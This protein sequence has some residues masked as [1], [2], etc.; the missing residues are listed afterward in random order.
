MFADHALKSWLTDYKTNGISL[1]VPELVR[2]RHH[3]KALD[4][5]PKKTPQA[6]LAGTYVT[7]LKGRG[8]EF[9]ESRHY[10]AGDDIRAIDWRVTARTGKT[11]TKVYREERERPIYVFTDMSSSMQFGSAFVFKSI[12]AAHLSTLIAW[13]AVA[14]GDK[15]GAISFNAH[16]HV[17]NKP[18][19]RQSAVLQHIH[20]LIGLQ[21]E[22][23]NKQHSDF[24]FDPD[25]QADQFSANCT[26]LMRLAKP[27]S[28]V[29]VISDFQNINKQSLRMLADLNRHSEVRAAV[30]YDP[31]EVKL[32]ETHSKQSL[33]ITDGKE[34]RGLTLGDNTVTQHYSAWA[35]SRNASLSQALEKAKISGLHV[36]AGSPLLQQPLHVI[37]NNYVMEHI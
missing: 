37:R 18:K 12:Q 4:L 26:R 10:Q 15:L 13:S 25:R 34:K 9:D 22:A 21:S 14:R 1:C 27:G 31:L 33:T 23:I 11:H 7:K 5:S 30:I 32:P 19:S 16:Q 24:N 3:T 28:L 8:M 6:R 17:E 20:Q 35:Q 36:S 29:W 2:Y